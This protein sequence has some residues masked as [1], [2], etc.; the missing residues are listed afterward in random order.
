MPETLRYSVVLA[1]H[2]FWLTARAHGIGVGWVSILD[3][4][5]VTEQLQVAADWTL[6]AY[7]CVGRALEQSQT[8][9]LERLG[10]QARTAVCR[11]ILRRLC[12]PPRRQGATPAYTG[13]GAVARLK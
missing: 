10:W 2:S 7:L 3:P 9:E 5:A 13:W 8:P 6:V 12:R 1:V 4:A 11:Q